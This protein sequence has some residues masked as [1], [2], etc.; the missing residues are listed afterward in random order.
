MDPDSQF[1]PTDA[2]WTIPEVDGD[3]RSK[4][5]NFAKTKLIP[6][7]ECRY[8]PCHPGFNLKR[9]DFHDGAPETEYPL[10]EEGDFSIWLN[11]ECYKEW[12][13]PRAVFQLAH[14]CL[15][16]LRPAQFGRAT[17]L[18]EGLATEFS[19]EP[20]NK[21]FPPGNLAYE[22]AYSHVQSLRKLL[23]NLDSLIAVY[24][25]N[26]PGRGISDI[27]RSDLRKALLPNKRI[28]FDNQ[29]DLGHLTTSFEYWRATLKDFLDGIYAM[30]FI[31]K[32]GTGHG[33]FV[34]QNGVLAG[35]D[36]VGGVL[37]GTYRH[38][39][40]GTLDVSITMTVPPG[41]WLVTGAVADRTPLTQEIRAT[42]PVDL[43]NGQPI[44]FTLPTGPVNVIFKRLRDIP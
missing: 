14:E 11:R 42:I 23:P 41:T 21:G 25:N 29:P 26:N 28:D 4:L 15:H 6:E 9:I 39:D 5:L 19:L 36:A 31:G 35:A 3:L 8:G 22:T 27:E 12:L 37:D 24:R 20:I 10:G 40:T 32:A 43:G 2:K 7:L 33:V 38:T 44:G 18:E 34:I 17:V 1:M 13:S 30:Y 16:A